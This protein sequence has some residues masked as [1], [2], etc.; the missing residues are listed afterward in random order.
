MVLPKA[1]LSTLEKNDFL[2]RLTMLANK[3]APKDK[4]IVACL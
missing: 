3:K 4:L 1:V 2:R